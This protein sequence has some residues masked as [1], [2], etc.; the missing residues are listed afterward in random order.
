MFAAVGT[1][2]SEGSPDDV[3]TVVADGE[4]LGGDG[5]DGRVRWVEERNVEHEEGMYVV[6]VLI[7]LGWFCVW[8][9]GNDPEGNVRPDRKG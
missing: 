9:D 7:R 4:L 2:C 5:E 1:T 3:R 6:W 8:F